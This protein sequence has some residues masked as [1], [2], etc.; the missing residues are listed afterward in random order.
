[1]FQKSRILVIST[2]GGLKS[3]RNLLDHTLVAEL[4]KP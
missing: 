4:L 1:M 3:R 2:V